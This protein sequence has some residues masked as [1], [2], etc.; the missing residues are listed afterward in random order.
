MHIF[1]VNKRHRLPSRIA[2]ELCIDK[3]KGM[4]MRRARVP[5]LNERVDNYRERRKSQWRAE[6]H[7]SSPSLIYSM[8]REQ[9]YIYIESVKKK[10]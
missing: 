8:P 5:L 4:R 9:Q 3:L 7:R 2:T 10:E 6:T 1:M